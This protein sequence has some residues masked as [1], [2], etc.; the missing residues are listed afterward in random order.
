MKL[1]ANF[2]GDWVEILKDILSKQWNYD[3]SRVNDDEVPLVYFNVEK[4][5]IEPVKR[6]VKLADTF[7]CPTDLKSGWE[8]LKT[9]IENGQDINSHLSKNIDDP[10]YKDSMLLDWGVH[11][12]HLIEKPRVNKIL[13][14]LVTK[15]CFYAI[16]I[17][18][19]RDWAKDSIVETIHRNWPEVI[20]RYK[21]EGINLTN[22]V[23]EEGRLVLR[24]K[25]AN[26]FTK[27]SDGTV[28]AP[29]GGGSTGS[30]DNIISRIRTDQQKSFLEKLQNHLDSLLPNL[31]SE[32]EKHGY[33]G[34]NE[35]EAKLIIA[36][37]NYIALFPAY[38]F[39][40]KFQ[41][42]GANPTL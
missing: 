12:F 23:P 17:Y 26:V 29:L 18:T 16:D 35:I 28:Y 40:V 41:F 3:I 8:T 19:H 10:F 11:H 36:E 31:R 30:G 1:K 38:K 25:N 20:A 2:V 9:E 42:G 13:F 4:R 37:D 39:T 21:I 6:S 7:V 5:R 27:V 15:N 34:E 22:S 33:N 14:A 32:L 24:S